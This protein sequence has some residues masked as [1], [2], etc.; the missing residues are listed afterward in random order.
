MLNA[1]FSK[2]KK[3]CPNKRHT[4]KNASLIVVTQL[5]F[6]SIGMSKREKHL[7]PRYSFPIDRNLCNYVTEA[8]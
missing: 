4:E 3:V 5:L 7:L 2:I 8:L 6:L 1:H